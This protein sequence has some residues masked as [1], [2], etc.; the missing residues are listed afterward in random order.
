MAD[1][2]FDCQIFKDNR[3]L[4]RRKC[5]GF[6]NAGRMTLKKQ[7]SIMSKIAYRRT[8][9]PKE[10]LSATDVL[11]TS[12]SNDLNLKRTRLIH[13]V[14]QDSVAEKNKMLAR[15]RKRSKHPLRELRIRAGMTLEE[16][17]IEINSSPSYLSRLESGARRLNADTIDRLSKVLLCSPAELLPHS[18]FGTSA[19]YGTPSTSSA[20]ANTNQIVDLPVYKLDGAKKKHALDLFT[21]E[22]WVARPPELQ[23]IKDAFACL[24]AN[25][26]WM[27][28]YLEGERLFIHPTAPLRPGV[29]IL[30]STKAGE[31]VIGTLVEFQGN[32][33]ANMK[34]IVENTF[35]SEL[36]KRTQKVVYAQKDL[37]T[38]YRVI[39]SLEAA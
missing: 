32:A 4:F 5:L 11:S 23:G 30:L 10:P 17:A 14:D 24:V 16:L 19:T 36:E 35:A 20:A 26:K 3:T 38:A 39:G 15:K 28:R 25:S 7:E 22:Q 6:E 29:T 1:L 27:P 21:P 33:T 31:V 2:C 12:F 13:S 9:V 8:A 34:M 37:E 18:T